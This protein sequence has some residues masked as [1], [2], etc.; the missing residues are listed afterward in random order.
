MNSNGRILF[1]Q[2]QNR[3]LS[4]DIRINGDEYTTT[5]YV[6]RLVA[7]AFLY[8]EENL[9]INHTSNLEYIIIQQYVLHTVSTEFKF[10]PKVKQLHLDLN[11]ISKYNISQ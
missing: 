3:Y 4:V 5:K 8:I 11:F 9:V 1:A 6:Y 2:L 10:C 7:A